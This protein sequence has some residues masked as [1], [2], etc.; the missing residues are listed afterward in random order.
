MCAGD[1]RVTEQPG[2][3]T[4]HTL[5]MR[6]HN[7]IAYNLAVVN[8]QWMDDRIYEE[9]RKII[10]GVMQHITYQ[11]YLPKV[12]FM[13]R[14]HCLLLFYLT[15][16]FNLQSCFLIYYDNIVSRLG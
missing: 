1:F 7:E 5:F 9:A 3:T 6:Q 16:N 2:L 15:W 11:E 12:M 14:F 13:F 8:P 10:G 4:L